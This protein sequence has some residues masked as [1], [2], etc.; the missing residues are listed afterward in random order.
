MKLPNGYGSIVFLGENRRRPYA[1]RKTEGWKLINGKAR[2]S[3]KYIDY[4][5]TQEEALSFLV[6]LNDRKV[7]IKK[8]DLT[9]GDIFD[10]WY[11]KQIKGKSDSTKISLKSRYKKMSAIHDVKI[12]DITEKMLQDVLDSAKSYSLKQPM[13]QIIQGVMS[14]AHAN[15]IRGDNPS[16]MLDIG[17]AVASTAHKVIEDLDE[18]KNVE[19]AE[20]IILLYYTGMRINELCGIEIENIHLDERYMIGGLKSDA[21]RERFIPIHKSQVEMIKKQM[22]GKKKYLYEFKG[23]KMGYQYFRAHHFDNILEENCFEPYTP[24]DTRHTFV[25]NM[26]NAGVE[27]LLIQKIVGHKPQDVTDKVYTHIKNE[28]LIEAIDMLG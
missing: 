5:E 26:R 25:T 17:K 18:L 1:V 7:D 27:K 21:G 13:R 28:E 8:I 11:D 24:H 23:K 16:T 15:G 19:G 20:H 6:Q 2:Q 14:L 4:F 10:Q 12:K 9:F 3:Y 22:E